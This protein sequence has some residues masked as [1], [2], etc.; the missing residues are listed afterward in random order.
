M[1]FILEEVGGIIEISWLLFILYLFIPVCKAVVDEV[2]AEVE[3]VDPN[4]KIDVGSFRL[5]GNGNIKQN[6]VTKHTSVWIL[7]W[8]HI[9]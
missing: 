7:V 9:K 1:C 5:D 8:F 3:K 2:E 6:L 4:K